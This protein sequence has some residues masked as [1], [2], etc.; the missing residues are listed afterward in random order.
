MGCDAAALNCM[1][2]GGAAE[3]E[4]GAGGGMA[5]CMPGCAAAA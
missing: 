2:G 5:V 1:G 3:V 4:G